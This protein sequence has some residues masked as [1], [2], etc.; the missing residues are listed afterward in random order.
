[1]PSIFFRE[2]NHYS[3][4][5]D[6]DRF[7]MQDGSYV[8]APKERQCFIDG[9]NIDPKIEAI[10]T[11]KVCSSCSEN[12]DLEDI[13]NLIKDIGAAVAEVKEQ[14]FSL[15]EKVKEL[16]NIIKTPQ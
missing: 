4:T 8:I 16:E 6:V 7:E 1:M 2:W 9:E 3:E 14:S 11:E 5:F 12:N 15:S 10:K 13:I